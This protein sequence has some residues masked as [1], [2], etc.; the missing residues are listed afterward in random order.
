M[1]MDFS[2]VHPSVT[3]CEIQITQGVLS[4]IVQLSNAKNRALISTFPTIET[5]RHAAQKLIK[6]V[7][8]S[9]V[10]GAVI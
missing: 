10:G 1:S 6:L 4:N 3:R 2:S 8:L 5:M 9:C 7:D